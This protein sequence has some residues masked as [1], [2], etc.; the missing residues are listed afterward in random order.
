MAMYTEAE[1]NRQLE[2]AI[3]SRRG[4]EDGGVIVGRRATATQE[5]ARQIMGL[6]FFG[7]EEAAK[8]FGITPAENERFSI[9]PWDEME[10]RRMKDTH[11]LIAVFPLSYV[12]IRDRVPEELFYCHEDAWHNEQAFATEKGEPTW[13]L[14]RK[15]AVENSLGKAWAKQQRRLSKDEEVPTARVMTYTIIG[16]F[17]ATGERLF[18]N[19]YVRCSDVA[20]GCRIHIGYFNAKEG[21]NLGG[22]SDGS[23]DSRVGVAAARK[24]LGLVVLS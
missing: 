12:E 20:D 4:C 5:A 6:N 11:V 2:E 16:H 1:P 10:L 19:A 3:I 14:V 9:I 23:R 21:L 17:L 13:E 7:I 24:K 8:H 15:T 22:A 18:E